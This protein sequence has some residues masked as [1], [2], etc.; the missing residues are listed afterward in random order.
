MVII[1]ILSINV[2][3]YCVNSAWSSYRQKVF[4]SGRNGFAFMEGYVLE[5]VSGGNIWSWALSQGTE[6]RGF[7][8]PSNDILMQ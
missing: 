4:N 1:I 7:L 3:A 6:R 2:R 5:Q 8:G